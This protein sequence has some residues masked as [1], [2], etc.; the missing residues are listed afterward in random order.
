MPSWWIV[1]APGGKNESH[2]SR[3]LDTCKGICMSEDSECAEF[4]I[5]ELKVK[6]LSSLMNLTDDM[7]KYEE[8][9]EATLKRLHRNFADLLTMAP[10]EEQK[11]WEKNPQMRPELNID[12]PS[13]GTLKPEDYMKRFQWDERKYLAKADLANLAGTIYAEIADMDNDVK[14]KQT[15]LT[16]INSRLNAIQRKRSGNLVTRDLSDL[17]KSEHYCRDPTT[18]RLS[19][20]IV[21]YFIVVSKHRVSDFMESY[22]WFTKLVVPGSAME[23][24]SDDK[25]YVLFRILALGVEAMEDQLKKSIEENKFVFRPFTF[26][27]EQHKETTAEETELIRKQES[28]RVE[29]MRAIQTNFSEMFMGWFHLKAIRVF[30]ESVLWYSLPPNFQ[31]MVIAPNERHISSLRAKLASEFSNAKCSQ[32]NSSAGGDE[33]DNYPY[34]NMDMD[35]DWLFEEA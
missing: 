31:V 20:W 22:E 21:P 4:P 27:P 19:E 5:P 15:E 8:R 23:V 26:E 7:Q 1:S 30:V 10:K 28:T 25:D 24:P 14:N 6:N 11:A 29:V 9:T 16:T 18:K 34:V 33:E 32:A 3:V 35:L 13:N 17:I 2:K 12:T